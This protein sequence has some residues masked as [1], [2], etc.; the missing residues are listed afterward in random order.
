[1]PLWSVEPGAELVCALPLHTGDASSTAT[2][3]TQYGFDYANG[4]CKRFR[5]SGLGG[6]DNRFDTLEGCNT[7]CLGPPTTTCTTTKSIKKKK[8]GKRRR[9]YGRKG[10]GHGRFFPLLQGLGYGHGYGGYGCWEQG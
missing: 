5:Y 9:G 6:N 2:A 10:Y 8:H 1:M 3:K 4:Q 7:F